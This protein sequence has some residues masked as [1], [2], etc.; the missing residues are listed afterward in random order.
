MGNQFNKRQEKV[1]SK[2]LFLLSQNRLIRVES[3]I[4][5]EEMNAI[6]TNKTLKKKEKIE[7][8]I[9]EILVAKLPPESLLAFVDSAKNREIILEVFEH[10]SKEKN[11]FIAVDQVVEFASNCLSGTNSE[12][13]ESSRLIGN[14]IK[15]LKAL[16]ESL[17][18][19]L[20]IN[21]SSGEGT[22][23]R[24]AAAFALVESYKAF[25]SEELKSLVNDCRNN[26][27]KNSIVK[28]YASVNE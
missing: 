13:R 12:K 22:V 16:P 28:I 15:Y 24:W 6:L 11:P 23:T 18:D 26:E 20:L 19:Q 4:G 25:P 3:E 8:L 2:R 27:Q 21:T 7:A 1:L 10:I 5:S 17:I 14:S 9:S